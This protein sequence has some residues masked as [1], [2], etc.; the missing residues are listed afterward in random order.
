MKI[1]VMYYFSPVIFLM[2]FCGSCVAFAAQAPAAVQPSTTAQPAGT[3]SSIMQPALDTLR[4]ALETLRPDKWKTSGPA[5]EEAAANVSSI[6]HDLE[7]TLPPLLAAADRAPGSVAQVL[8]AYRNIEALYDVVLRVSETGNFSAPT[9]QIAALEQARAQLEDARRA[10]GEHLQSAALAQD[11]QVRN[12]Q[13]AVRAVPPAP[14]P[15][16]CPSPSPVKHKRRRKPATK[17]TPAP[18]SSQTAPSH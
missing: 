1:N 8:P 18:A 12:L 15:V 2:T 6:G 7:T 13:V 16:V 11:Q 5:R 3:P 14:A 17:H 4:Q 10:L 9:Q